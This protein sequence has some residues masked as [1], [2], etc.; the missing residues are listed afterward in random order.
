MTDYM[1]NKR[2]FEQHYSLASHL[3]AASRM[4]KKKNVPQKGTFLSD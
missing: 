1:L 3:I 4:D 2:L